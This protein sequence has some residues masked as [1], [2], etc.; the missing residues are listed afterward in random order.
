MVIDGTD[1]K[2][3][4]PSPPDGRRF[5]NPRTGRFLPFN[6]KWFTPK[7]N[8]PGLRYETATCI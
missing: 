3:Y 6:P 8:G 7:H 2:I 1:Y 4:E 5:V